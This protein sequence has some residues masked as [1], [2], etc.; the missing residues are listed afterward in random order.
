[1]SHAPAK[2]VQHERH[3]LAPAGDLG[4]PPCRLGGPLP[5]GARGICGAGGGRQCHRRRRRRRH[6]AGRAAERPRQCRRRGA[7]HPLPRR[8]PEGFHGER[9][10][11]VAPAGDARLFHEAPRR[12]DP[13]RPVAH[14]G[15]GGARCLD[16]DAAA[17]GHHELRR[18]G[19]GRGAFRQGRLRRPS[20]AVRD[21]RHAPQGIRGVAVEPGHLSAQR[22]SAAGGRGVRAERPRPQPAVHDRPG[23][24]GFGQGPRGRPGGG[25]GGVLHRRPRPHDRRLSRSERRPAAHGRPGR[26]PLRHRA[27][28]GRAVRRFLGA[29]L[30]PVVPGAGAGPDAAPGRGH[31]LPQA[32]AQFLR[33][34][35]RPDR[36]HEARLRR[37]ARL[38]RRS[39]VRRRA[40]R[41][42]AVARLCG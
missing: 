2:P 41:P 5:G 37:P 27:V 8:E 16:P 42:I 20:A 33:L 29:H 22:A 35:A 24:G 14:G 36:D 32:A 11:R 4:P 3:H 23:E 1:M 30:R 7:D 28:R 10:G 40:A 6:R 15:A 21:H 26:V 38:L 34:R 9:P 31:G 25:A 19:G 17:L 13:A 12:Q 39:Q 18:C